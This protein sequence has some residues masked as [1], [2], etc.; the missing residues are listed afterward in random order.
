MECCLQPITR[1]SKSDAELLDSWTPSV[2]RKPHMKDPSTIIEYGVPIDPKV[3]I[4]PPDPDT[5][6]LEPGHPGLGD[7][8]YVERRNHL[9]A[10][11]RRHRLENLRPPLVDYTPEETRIWRDVAHRLDE[12]HRA[13]ACSIYLEAKEALG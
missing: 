8:G 7:A 13:H 5:L 9:F 6:Q 12:L 4:E 11:C 10:L 3:M 1:A 2:A